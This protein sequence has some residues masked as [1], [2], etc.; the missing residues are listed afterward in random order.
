MKPAPIKTR[1]SKLGDTTL[2]NADGST[3]LPTGGLAYEDTRV[4]DAPTSFGPEMAAKLAVAELLRNFAAYDVQVKAVLAG[5]TRPAQVI[6][7][8][9]GA[10]AINW[11]EQGSIEA[12]LKLTIREVGSFAYDDCGLSGPSMLHDTVDKFGKGTV[13]QLEADCTG[14]VSV[15]LEVA[16]SSVRDAVR[17]ALRRLFA[18]E[19]GDTRTGRRV[20][21]A[22]YYDCD[23]RLSLARGAFELDDS[24]IQQGKWGLTCLLDVDVPSVR[25]LGSPGFFETVQVPGR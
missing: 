9:S 15:E 13:L 3:G 18:E 1:T 21:L 11:P 8:A 10:V 6:H 17:L 22:S 24:Q 12:P 23:V 19:P 14:Q 2:R 20:V 4:V 7:L 5:D 25:L 16:A